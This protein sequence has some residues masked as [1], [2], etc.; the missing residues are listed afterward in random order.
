ME[1]EKTNKNE[2]SKDISIKF[3]IKY[4]ISNNKDLWD[5]L[6][7][8]EK[9]EDLKRTLKNFLMQEY[10]ISDIEDELDDI[11]D[12]IIT[13]RKDPGNY[14]IGKDGRAL[15]KITPDMIYTSPPSISEDGTLRKG[16]VQLHPKISGGITL[17]IH[18]KTRLKIL[19]DKYPNSPAL[20]HLKDTWSIIEVATRELTTRGLQISDDDALEI[21]EIEFGREAI[22]T[23][24]Q[25]FNKDFVRYESFGVSLSKVILKENKR[26]F[27][28]ISCERLTNSKF[29]WYKAKVLISD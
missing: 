2:L 7:K 15:F 21:K 6:A 11:T 18:E 8:C 29:S 17:A 4:E 27:R 26:K 23:V 10:S 13:L 24:F 28:F 19:E 3:R 25:S 20:W 12:E 5:A 16:Q 14:L 22:N 1:I 9:S